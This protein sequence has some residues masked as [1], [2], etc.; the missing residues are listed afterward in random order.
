MESVEKAALPSLHSVSKPVAGEQVSDVGKPRLRC[1][2][3]YLD[4]CPVLDSASTAESPRFHS[5]PTP[6]KKALKASVEAHAAASPEAKRAQ[7][8]TMLRICVA[9]EVPQNR[10][11]ERPPGTEVGDRY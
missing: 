7:P 10:R 2:A 1:R 9:L 4:R 5:Y 6:P 8:V 3:S 11:Q